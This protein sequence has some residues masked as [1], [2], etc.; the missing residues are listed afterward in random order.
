MLDSL[1]LKRQIMLVLHRILHQ[2]FGKQQ[3][4]I[5]IAEA[6]RGNRLLHDIRQHFHAGLAFRRGVSCRRIRRVSSE[7]VT[8]R[9]ADT[10]CESVNSMD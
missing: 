3:C 6:R 5:V 9:S 8:L 1:K 7:S 4:L 2:S 10:L